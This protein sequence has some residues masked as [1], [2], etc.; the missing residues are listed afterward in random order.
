M[1]KY[2]PKLFQIESKV[3]HKAVLIKAQNDQNSPWICHFD[4]LIQRLG[5]RQN[6]PAEWYYL[7]CIHCL[8]IVQ[9]K[10][11]HWVEIHLKFPSSSCPPSWMSRC[12]VSLLPAQRP[13]PPWSGSSGFSWA[14]PCSA[15]TSSSTYTRTHSPSSTSTSSQVLQLHRNTHTLTHSDV[16]THSSLSFSFSQVMRECLS[17]SRPCSA[18]SSRCWTNRSP[19]AFRPLAHLSRWRLQVIH[20]LLQPLS[21]S[22]QEQIVNFFCFISLLGRIMSLASAFFSLLLGPNSAVPRTLLLQSW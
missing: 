13:W 4:I 9:F 15:W 8:Y 5:Y 19:L 6:R 14:W 2:N 11:P 21:D 16:L 18:T 22:P 20:L 12:L 3:K 10:A 17:F 1:H 7:G